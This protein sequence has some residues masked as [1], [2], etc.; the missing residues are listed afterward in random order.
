MDSRKLLFSALAL[1]AFSGV[2]MGNTIEVE[3]TAINEKIEVVSHRWPPSFIK[4]LNEC[5]Q[6]Y[7]EVLAT[8][9]PVVGTSQAQLI[10]QGA[11]TG[12][13]GGI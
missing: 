8:Y 11:W 2:S 4:A 10:A 9:T 6:V 3:E 5:A 1:V 12:C 13:M 7:N